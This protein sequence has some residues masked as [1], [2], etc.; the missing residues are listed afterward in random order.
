MFCKQ[1]RGGSF[2]DPGRLIPYLKREARENGSFIFYPKC[3]YWDGFDFR[4]LSMLLPSDGTSFCKPCFS[5]CGL[6]ENSGATN[7]QNYHL[8]IAK[9]GGDFIASWALHIHE[10]G[11]G[12]LHQALLVFPLL[13]LW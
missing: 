1:A 10:V 12:A 4:V 6:A 13:L 3:A 11:I 8:C 9:N 2:W 5:S 7:T